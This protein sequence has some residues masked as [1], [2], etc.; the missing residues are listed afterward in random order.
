M[1]V[2]ILKVRMWNCLITWLYSVVAG[3]KNFRDIDAEKLEA[4]F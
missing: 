2:K 3:K 1:T 4:T